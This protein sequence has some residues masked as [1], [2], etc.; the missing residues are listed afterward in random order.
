[1]SEYMSSGLI[2]LQNAAVR[3]IVAGFWIW[4]WSILVDAATTRMSF[5]RPSSLSGS[6]AI[7]FL[8]RRPQHHGLICGRCVWASHG[9]ECAGEAD[10]F[11]EA[12]ALDLGAAPGGDHQGRVWL[13][14]MDLGPVKL[15]VANQGLELAIQGGGDGFK[16]MALGEPISHVL[17]LD[18]GGRTFAEVA[19]IYMAPHMTQILRASYQIL[20]NVTTVDGSLP[21]DLLAAKDMIL[22]LSSKI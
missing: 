16:L 22:A 5:S 10:K 13:L 11:I 20:D 14:G 7:P 17:E 12:E 19:H 8:Y 4:T 15:Q 6:C 1:M 9:S 18:G 3:A 21:C 2:S